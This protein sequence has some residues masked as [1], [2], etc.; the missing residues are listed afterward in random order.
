ML[1]LTLTLHY[2]IGSNKMQLVGPSMQSPDTRGGVNDPGAVQC[3]ECRVQSAVGSVQCRQTV[4]SRDAATSNKAVYLR[5]HGRMTATSN[6]N[7]SRSLSAVTVHQCKC[8]PP[9]Q[10][11]Q[12]P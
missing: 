4:A 8:A 12:V 10:L 6:C 11:P 7:R 3:A 5:G 2:Q 1:W 9:R